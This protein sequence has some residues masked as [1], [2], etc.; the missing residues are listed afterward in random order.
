MPT[1]FF[2]D[3]VRELCQEGGTGP[4]TPT[5]AVPGHRRFADAVPA[6]A[7][8]H[9]AIAGIAWPGEWEVGSG[10]LDPAGRLVRDS[11]AASSNAGGRVDFAPGLKTIALTVAAGW[12]AERDA[13][14]ATLGSAVDGLTGALAAKQP[15]STVHGSAA[16]AEPSDLVTIRRGGGWVNVPMSALALRDSGGRY[17]LAGTLAG[18]NGSAGAP[19]IS[20]A[21]D[22]DSGMFRAASDAIGFAT[23]GAERMRL[24]AGGRVGIGR[25]DPRAPL[26]MAAPTANPVLAAE[27]GAIEIKFDVTTVLAIGGGTNH[28]YA[29]WLQ[30]KQDNA[31]Y[32]STAFPIALN[33]LGGPVLT[34]GAVLPIVDNGLALGSAAARFSTVYAG[35]GAINTSD[36][37]GKIW[38]SAPNDAELRAARRILG[39][40]GFYQW[41]DALERKGADGARYHF[42]VRAQ[43]VWAIMADEG[44]VDPL[45][46]AGRPG[47]TPYAFLCWDGW[48]AVTESGSVGPEGARDAGDRFGIR[49]DQLALFL[50][51]AQD[52]R[53]ALLEAA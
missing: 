46:A 30:G 4:L 24:T 17:P 52:R 33:P 13:A 14:A 18:I 48:D 15:V 32:T 3:L 20:F 28:G 36:A 43:A 51:A 44:L 16:T 31:G 50:I 12:F 19:A 39:E 6:G 23:A 34:G 26:S 37:R 2:A 9:Y 47:N 21:A 45:D 7:P 42:G 35:T 11:V 5:G 29:L 8:F 1:L 40:L 41:Q 10:H 53:L 49:P 38:R 27:A 25:S 22:L